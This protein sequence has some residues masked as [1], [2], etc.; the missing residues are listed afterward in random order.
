MFE[1]VP[2]E[3]NVP[4]IEKEILEFWDSKRYRRSLPR[5]ECRLRRAFL[6]SRRTDHG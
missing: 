5:A 3:F 2:K 4:A 1:Q 6:L